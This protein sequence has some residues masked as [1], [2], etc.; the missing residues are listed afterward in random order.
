[1]S[2]LIE[3]LPP[4]P[5]APARSA[6]A[7]RR[8]GVRQQ[9]LAGTT[10]LVVAWCLLAIGVSAHEGEYSGWGLVC[11]TLGFLLLVAVVARGHEVVAPTRRL[12]VLPATVAVVAA[13]AHPARRLMHAHGGG[14]LALDVLAR[15][16]APVALALLVVPRGPH[17]RWLGGTIST[18]AGLVT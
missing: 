17:P 5:A 12:L 11:V 1:M 15:A 9:V 7:D 6:I 8:A 4:A 18:A 13:A 3:S 10:L 14:L 16:T 2:E